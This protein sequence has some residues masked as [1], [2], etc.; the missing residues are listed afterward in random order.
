M[1]LEKKPQKTG[2]YE[3]GYKKPPQ[4]EASKKTRFGG[5]RGNPRGHGYFKVKDTARAK[6]EKMITLS[7]AELE[8]I[9]AD[10]TAPKFEH[11]LADILLDRE[12]KL[13]EKWKIIKDIIDEVY[14][15]PA[16]T[17][18]NL[19]TEM[20]EKE[21]SGFIKGFFVPGDKDDITGAGR[22]S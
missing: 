2:E 8:E 1:K 14:G 6:L 4:T 21:K 11:D 5:E 12:L 19:N 18:V 10:E 9:K 7:K 13:S 22:E 17:T 3:I 16:Q 15:T 20:D